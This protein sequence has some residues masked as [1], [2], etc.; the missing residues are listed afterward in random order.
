M[1]RERVKRPRDPRLRRYRL[2]AMVDRE[3]RVTLFEYALLL[4]LIVLVCLIAVDLFGSKS[5]PFSCERFPS[6]N[7]VTVPA[8]CR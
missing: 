3:H 1:V 7:T 6:T 5:D 2:L 8:A 4:A